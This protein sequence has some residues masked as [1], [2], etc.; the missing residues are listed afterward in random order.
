M[1]YR[2]AGRKVLDVTFRRVV[3]PSP[4]RPR[5]RGEEVERA[6][7]R[8]AVAELEEH[9]Y[10]NFTM[11]GVAAR[12]GTNKPMI[13]RRWPSRPALAFAAYRQLVAR[14]DAVPDT[15]DLRSD[16]VALLRSA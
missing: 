1:N 12:A 10:E 16:V 7:L 11:D 13:Y 15:G 14:P 6:V 4:K 3:M 9:G 2:S 8:A 5:R